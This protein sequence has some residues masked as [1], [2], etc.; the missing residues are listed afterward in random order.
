MR[1]RSSSVAPSLHEQ[2]SPGT[3][4][5]HLCIEGAP[6]RVSWRNPLGLPEPL[7]TRQWLYIVGPQMIGAAIVDGLANFGIACAMYRTGAD[8][9]SMW[10][11]SESTVAGDLGV[12]VLIQGTL[13]FIIAGSMVHVDMR[14]GKPPAFPYPWPDTRFAVVDL[15]RPEDAKSRRG[16][17]WRMFH[18]RHGIGRGLHFFSGSDVNDL[19]DFKVGFKR[20]V[21][22]FVLTAIKG[23]LLS[24]LYFFVFWP[25]AIACVAPPYGGVNMAHSWTPPIIKLVF[26]FLLGLFMNPI[27]ACI[28]LGSEDAVRQ[29]RRE[30]HDKNVREIEEAAPATN[31]FAEKSVRPPEQAHFH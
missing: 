7:T 10:K 28:A 16:A 22:R 12:T 24:A 2:W 20:W 18:Q 9:I 25:I 13:T 11:L 5:Q 23:A 6:R 14:N 19:F 29:H 21:G 4:V 26:G 27:V 15:G 30:V 17:V 31:T 8:P 3:P 1:A